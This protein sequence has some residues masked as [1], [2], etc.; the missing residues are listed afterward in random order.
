VH[1]GS[2]INAGV[3]ASDRLII[4]VVGRIAIL[5]VGI[6]IVVIAGTGS[7]RITDD[8]RPGVVVIIT[9]I[10]GINRRGIVVVC[11]ITI[12][13]IVVIIIPVVIIVV[14][15]V[16]II[17]SRIII[18]VPVITV[19]VVT[20]AAVDYQSGADIAKRSGKYRQTHK[21]YAN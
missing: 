4:T 2:A 9:V 16:I 15:I 18:V 13:I 19:V 7:H 8:R 5:L 10:V 17:A 1:V 14:V 21:S 6:A 12:I 20:V 11:R 3:I